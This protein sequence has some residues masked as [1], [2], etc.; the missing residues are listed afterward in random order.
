MNTTVQILDHR[1]PEERDREFLPGMGKPWLL[2]FYDLFSLRVGARA[3]HDRAAALADVAPGESVLDVGCGTANLSLAVLRAQ[4]A[5]R[6]TGLDPDAGALRVAA[7]KATRRRLPLTLVQGFADRLPTGDASLDH[8]VSALALHHVPDEG[9]VLFG[10]EAFRALRPGGTVTIVDL[11]SSD[12]ADEGADAGGHGRG[13]GHGHE[14]GR[15]RLRGH[16]RSHGHGKPRGHGPSNLVRLLT[17]VGFTDAR[18]VEHT[19]HRFGPMAFVQ[20][21]RA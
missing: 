18:E 14:H 19:E 7:R 5:A 4:P 15:G 21:T 11:G 13:A 1:T 16:G 9:R 6:V 17:D 12:G 8:I 20:A 10:R 2:P 3:L